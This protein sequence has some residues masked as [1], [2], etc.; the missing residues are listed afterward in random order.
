MNSFPQ[1]FRPSNDPVPIT[2][3]W[4]FLYIFSTRLQDFRVLLWQNIKSRRLLLCWE[5]MDCGSIFFLR[6]MD[7]RYFSHFTSIGEL[8]IVDP[9]IFILAL[10]SSGIRD[11]GKANARAPTLFYRWW[12]KGR[13]NCSLPGINGVEDSVHTQYGTVAAQF[14]WLTHP[15]M[16]PAI[17]PV[18][19]HAG[20]VRVPAYYQYGNRYVGVKPLILS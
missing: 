17:Q 13:A 18:T 11:Y 1:F 9:S 15:V 12:S 19:I 7:L 5:P 2:D 8:W 3:L 10:L 14:Y 20:T 6:L 16:L 4:Q